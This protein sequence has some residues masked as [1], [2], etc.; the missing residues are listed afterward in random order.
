MRPP[1][2]LPPTRPPFPG[3]RESGGRDDSSDRGPGLRW[4][5]RPLLQPGLTS[6][7]RPRTACGPLGPGLRM[8]PGGLAFIKTPL[9]P[10]RHIFITSK[11]QDLAPPS[12]E[13]ASHCPPVGEPPPALVGDRGVGQG[14]GL[15]P[16]HTL[17]Y[18][19]PGINS[20]WF[21]FYFNFF[22]F[23]GFDFF[24]K[25]FH[26][27]HIYTEGI[28]AVYWGELDPELEW[29]GSWGRGNGSEGAPTL[30]MSPCPL[31][32]PPQPLPPQFSL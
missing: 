4:T 15:P 8:G 12:S 13:L 2:A 25:N 10:P 20:R 30:S 26:F 32:P 3:G 28:C 14:W 7:S 31:S 6:G 29:G 11:C 24:N 19:P 1:P 23:F 16:V 21:C 5:A 22:F 9:C 18:Q 27:K 17:P